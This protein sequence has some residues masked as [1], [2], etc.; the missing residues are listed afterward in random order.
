MKERARLTGIE[1]NQRV[2][3]ETHSQFWFAYQQ[4]VLLALKDGG[5]LTEAQYRYAEETLKNQLR[6]AVKGR[7]GCSGE[8][9]GG[10]D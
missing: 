2:T 8:A 6:T 4:A 1:R 3:K 10:H 5:V 7:N 9:G